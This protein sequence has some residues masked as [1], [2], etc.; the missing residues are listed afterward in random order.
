MPDK[1]HKKHIPPSAGQYSVNRKRKQRRLFLIIVIA[2]IILLT[3]GT[4]V[5]FYFRTFDK[6]SV[7]TSLDLPNADEQTVIVPYNRG[8]M[9]CS[10]EGVTYFD[11]KGILWAEN[12]EMAQPI[13]ACCGSY[14]AAADMKAKDV[15]LYDTGG[16]SNRIT[17][18]HSITDLE[19]SEQ[20]VIAAATTEGDSNFIEV[21]DREGNELWFPMMLEYF[22]RSPYAIR[23]SLKDL[24]G[25]LKHLRH[26]Q[27]LELRICREIFAGK[28]K[29]LRSKTYE[30]N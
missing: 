22:N 24:D 8:Y 2:A 25:L 18:G 6:V 23:R 12:F 30:L 5:Y 21:V 16:L 15:Y 19:V 3:A 28:A 7:I 1:K 13:T 20:G 11:K 17:L 26:R 10:S 14:F 27:E 4:W 29:V 9:R